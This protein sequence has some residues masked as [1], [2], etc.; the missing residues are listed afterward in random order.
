MAQAGISV[1]FPKVKYTEGLEEYGTQY[2]NWNELVEML[3]P[4]TDSL[5][6]DIIEQY[7]ETWERLADS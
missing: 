7:K 6:K 5:V 1:Y 3:L 4:K 2:N